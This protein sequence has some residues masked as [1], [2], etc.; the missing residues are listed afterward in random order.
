MNDLRVLIQQ[1]LETVATIDSGIPLADDMVEDNQTYF[2]YQLMETY[3]DS[4]Y[5]KNYS[6][7]VTIIG[8]LERK[9]NASENTVLILDN[10]L[11]EL[12]NALKSIN[13]KCTYQD[14]TFDNNIRKISVTGV[15]RYNQINH[16]LI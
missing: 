1:T 15:V 5:D 14:V 10:A 11:E 16:F 6:M 12:I 2:G 4:D 7:Q 9:A 13:F 8:Q 3:I